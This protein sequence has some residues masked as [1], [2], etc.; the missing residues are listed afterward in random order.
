L[1]TSATPYLVAVSVNAHS[2]TMH[3]I[4]ACR[5]IHD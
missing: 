2:G 1:V 5:I 3:T 4:L